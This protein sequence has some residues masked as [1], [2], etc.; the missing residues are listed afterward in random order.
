MQTQKWHYFQFRK[1]HDYPVYLRF[2]HEELNPKF[3]HLLSELGFNELTDIESKKI[4]LQ[5][6]YT[7]MLTVQF[8]SSRLDQQLNGSDLLDKYGSEILSIQ[9]NTPIY[10]YR[11]VGIMALPTN[12][13][14]WD[15]A[16]HSE[17]SHTDQMIGFRIILVRFISQ[18][19]AD[20]G[21]LCYWGTVRDESVIV[22]KQAQSFGEAVFIDWNKKIIFSNG[23]EM[24]F[25]SHL[26][27][28]RKDKESKTTGSMGREEVISFLS[29]STCLLS[30]SGI[31][32]PMKRAIIEMSA[33]VTTSY[34]VSEGSA[35]L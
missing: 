16:L 30:F 1:L 25:N 22:M 28:L 15:L 21:V 5:R 14:L 23:G 7:R 13:T 8:A 12:K 31:T 10:T 4:P 29:V 27:I 17:I 6:A 26:K 32:N 11:K 34:S 35:N 9:A 2:K 33:K 19:L 20:Q 24:K 3:S 18:A